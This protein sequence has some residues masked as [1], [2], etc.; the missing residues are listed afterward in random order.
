M[1]QDNGARLVTGLLHRVHE[2]LCEFFSFV[3]HAGNLRAQAPAR[4]TIKVN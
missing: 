4:I 3:G 1:E 2:A